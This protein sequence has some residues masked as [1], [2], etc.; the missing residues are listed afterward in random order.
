MV[1]IFPNPASDYVVVRFTEIGSE[2]NDIA[3]FNS[4][5]QQVYRIDKNS[6]NDVMHI[7]STTDF[8][9]GVY[10]IR[11]MNGSNSL[12]RKLIVE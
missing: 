12:T 7:I 1:Q 11:I 2:K 6:S 10:M 5:G 3:I 8:T 9:P 4:L